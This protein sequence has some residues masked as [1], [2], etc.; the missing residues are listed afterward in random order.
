MIPYNLVVCVLLP[1]LPGTQSCQSAEDED[2]DEERE[3]TFEVSFHEDLRTE[4]HTGQ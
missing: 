1:L 4:A 2:E 3:K